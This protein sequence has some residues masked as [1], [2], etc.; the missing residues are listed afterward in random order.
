MKSPIL[1]VFL[2]ALTSAA[3]AQSADA[4]QKTLALQAK[5][6]QA[7]GTDAAF[8]TAVKAQNGKR[9][10]AGQMKVLDEQWAAGKA[11]ELVR[12]VTIGPSAD[13]LRQLVA[14]NPS[15]GESFVMDN[16]GAI[17][18]AT[19]KT[20]DYWQG[21]EAKWQRAFNDGKGAVFIDRPKLDESAAKRLAQ[22]SVPVADNGQIIGVLTVGITIGK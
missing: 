10:P 22:I 5:T 1:A 13:K 17:V 18:C 7:W 12:Q 11:T 3:S 20:S 16:Q 19:A 6:I 14:T 21:D 2:L 15:Y 8:I 9:V 4:M